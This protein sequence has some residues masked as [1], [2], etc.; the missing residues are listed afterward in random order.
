MSGL[1]ADAEDR[2]T[3]A[4][5]D[6]GAASADDALQ[7]GDTYLDGPYVVFTAQY[8]LRRGFCCNS[9]CRHCPYG[10]GDAAG[11]CDATNT[12]PET[13]GFAR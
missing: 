13:E 1:P 11:T 8:H 6:G 7:P 12:H 4:G 2:V 5:E 10:V 9:G 3:R